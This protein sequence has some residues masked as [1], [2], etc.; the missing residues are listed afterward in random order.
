MTAAVEIEEKI[1]RGSYDQDVST[2]LWTLE[3]AGLR[4]KR[5]F[6]RLRSENDRL[7]AENEWMKERIADERQKIRAMGMPP[8][9]QTQ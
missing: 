1:A 6:D 3:N 9:Y 4:C 8:Q 5:G 7:R 2:F